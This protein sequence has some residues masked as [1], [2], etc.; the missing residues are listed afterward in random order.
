MA[1]ALRTAESVWDRVQVGGPDECW[2]WLGCTNAK[3]YGQ[4][5][6]DGRLWAVHRDAYETRVGPIPEGLT[7]DHLCRNTGC[8]N[9][10]HLEA[11]TD[12]VN[13]ARRRNAATH[14]PHGHEYT[15]ANSVTLWNGYRACRTCINA[16]RRAKR[17]RNRP[18]VD[19]DPRVAG[20]PGH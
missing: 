6:H 20:C 11:V 10:R 4:H 17:R 5:Y 2:P 13:Q 19:R 9:P 15:E 7:I 1:R 8:C 3:G 18:E 16:Q 12:A 14:C